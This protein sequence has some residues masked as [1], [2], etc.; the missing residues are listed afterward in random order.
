LCGLA[1]LVVRTLSSTYTARLVIVI[2]VKWGHLFSDGHYS[3]D[4]E[5]KMNE[6]E[7]LHSDKRKRRGACVK[8]RTKIGL[9]RPL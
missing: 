4:F 8:D 6:S 9:E 5:M 7:Q 2:I 3:L 1:S